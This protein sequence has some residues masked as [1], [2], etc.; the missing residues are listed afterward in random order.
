MEKNRGLQW[1]RLSGR[2]AILCTYAGSCGIWLCLV[3]V[4]VMFRSS[5]L[6]RLCFVELVI[7]WTLETIIFQRGPGSRA[8][9]SRQ[10]CRL[11]G[12]GATWIWRRNLDRGTQNHRHAYRTQRSLQS[13]YGNCTTKVNAPTGHRKA[14]S[15]CTPS[16]ALNIRTASTKKIDKDSTSIRRA[17]THLSRRRRGSSGWSIGVLVGLDNGT[18]HR[19]SKTI[20]RNTQVCLS[21][22]STFNIG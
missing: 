3:V 2:C 1:C 4:S 10:W 15:D 21:T 16:V 7:H 9:R 14:F 19:E 20:Q 18:F 22:G 8:Q 5:L 11:S 13:D 17:N 6:F 12:R